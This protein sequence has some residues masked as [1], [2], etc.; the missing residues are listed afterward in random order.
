M[1]EVRSVPARVRAVAGPHTELA[2]SG[3]RRVECLV[4]QAVTVPT[5]NERAAVAADANTPPSILRELASDKAP[6]VREAVASNPAAPADALA[7]L[8]ADPK[9]SVSWAVAVTRVR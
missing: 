4:R 8:A 9:N 6:K 5:I 1:I 3:N 2:R 7:R